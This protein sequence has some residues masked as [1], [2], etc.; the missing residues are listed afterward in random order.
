M[1]LDAARE[2]MAERGLPQVTLRE[3]AD[4]AGVKPALV[5]YY[6]GGK[7]G[8][9][10]AVTEQVAA[11][12]RESLA[13]IAAIEGSAPERLRGLIEGW[14]SVI[15]KV[16]YAPRLLL[17]QVLF[18]GPEA[19]DDFTERFA[20]PNLD[21]FRS[22]LE[23]GAAAGEFRK[24]VDPA[25]FMPAVTGSMAFFF[26]AAPVMQRILDLPEIT[27]EICSA[28]AESASKLLLE[29]VVGQPGES[30]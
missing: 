8:L 25:L 10:D 9:L 23:S 2:L 27:P 4:R 5:A 24:D 7:K 20:R 28:Y 16:P 15:S 17:E 19:I 29:G 12:I 6:F 11:E 22:L 14:V 1:L 18:A 21:I 13:S 30:T 26:L 3:V